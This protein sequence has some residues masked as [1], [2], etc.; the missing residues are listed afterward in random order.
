MATKEHDFALIGALKGKPNTLN[1]SNRKLTSLSSVIGKITSIQS[2]I[3]KNNNLTVLPTELIYLKKLKS[4]NLGCNRFFQLPCVFEHTQSIT[5]LHLFNNLITELDPKALCGLKNLKYL[6]LNNNQLKFIPTEINRLPYLEVLSLDNNEITELPTETCQLSKLT[7]LNINCN[8]L[9]RLPDKIAFLKDLKKLRARKNMITE[10]PEGLLQC[11]KLE[12]LDIAANCIKSFPNEILKLSL[13]ELHCEE[14][15]LLKHL[16]VHSIQQQ[17]VLTL[18][19]QVARFILLQLKQSDSVLKKQIK[20]FPE[21]GDQLNLGSVCIV[22]G[23]PF[24]DTWLECV[25]F[26]HSQKMLHTK[27]N[28]G[29]IPIT[30][31]LCSYQCFNQPDHDFFAIAK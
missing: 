5:I 18:K 10:L 17:E 27:N 22:C 12:I 25:Q 7:E 24:L 20:Y 4:I 2:L 23:R 6:N 28:A 9:Q 26:I 3:L 11:S 21:L 1:L 16:P 19:E 8:K 13:Q 14:N 30:S 15:N 29:I 31:H